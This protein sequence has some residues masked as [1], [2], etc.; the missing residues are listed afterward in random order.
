MNRLLI[1][2]FITIAIMAATILLG[3]YYFVK[4]DMTPACFMPPPGMH[5]AASLNATTTPPPV[6]NSSKFALQ[7][8]NTP[9]RGSLS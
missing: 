3:L 1:L 4:F 6:L 5:A 7:A 2:K 9:H 8:L